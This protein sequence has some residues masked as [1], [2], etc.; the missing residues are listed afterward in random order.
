MNIDQLECEYE[1]VCAEINDQRQ[2]NK[3]HN[4]NIVLQVIVAPS[5]EERERE[6]G[7]N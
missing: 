3:S 1:C 5:R 2:V 7:A 4:V 6:R